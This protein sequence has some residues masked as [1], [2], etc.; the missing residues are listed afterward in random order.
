MAQAILV[1]SE[2]IEVRP[3]NLT[4]FQLSQVVQAVRSDCLSIAVGAV[5]KVVDVFSPN[6]IVLSSPAHADIFIFCSADLKPL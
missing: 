3:P 2:I 4:V 6:N 5:T 1:C